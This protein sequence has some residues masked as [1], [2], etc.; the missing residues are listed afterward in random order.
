VMSGL[1]VAARCAVLAAGLAVGALSVLF[2]WRR[3]L[4]PES[5]LGRLDRWLLRRRLRA[6]GGSRGVVLWV[7]PGGRLLRA[8]LL[9]ANHVRRTDLL[10]GLGRAVCLYLPGVV[11]E[12]QVEAVSGRL[13]RVFR[14]AGF[15]DFRMLAW[16]PWTAEDLAR[17]LA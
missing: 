4:L 5:R 11:T 14:K 10:L 17:V 16:P 1:S 8:G 2:L 6:M 15:Q 12:A 13:Q 9:A 7:Y 3:P